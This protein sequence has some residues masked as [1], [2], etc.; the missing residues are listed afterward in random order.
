MLRASI[1][2]TMMHPCSSLL[3]LAHEQVPSHCSGADC[4]A[5]RV[6]RCRL[7]WLDLGN[8]EV[9]VLLMVSGW[10]CCHIQRSSNGGGAGATGCAGTVD[11]SRSGGSGSGELVAAEVEDLP[12]GTCYRK[13]SCGCAS[14]ASKLAA[15]GLD[16]GADGLTPHRL[17]DHPRQR[18]GQSNGDEE[19]FHWALLHRR[20]AS[21]E[22]RR[23]SSVPKPFVAG[24]GSK[25]G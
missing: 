5:Q 20:C 18:N 22:P 3:I 11:H 17:L 14:E 16:V 25:G 15:S 1:F 8:A 23:C 13:H 12:C 21:Y 24:A 2:P 6:L 10:G 19:A 7:E 4:N 9:G